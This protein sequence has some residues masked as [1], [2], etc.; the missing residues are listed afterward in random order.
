MSHSHSDTGRW[1]C[2]VADASE[3]SLSRERRGRLSEQLVA[4]CTSKARPAP[5]A[6][7]PR[8]RAARSSDTE[9]AEGQEDGLVEAVALEGLVEAGAHES[10]DNE[11]VGEQCEEK[12]G[13]EEDE[14]HAED[15]EAYAGTRHGNVLSIILGSDRSESE[16]ES[17][18]GSGSEAMRGWGVS[19]CVSK[20]KSQFL[21]HVER[22]LGASL[23]LRPLPSLRT[24]QHFPLLWQGSL[25]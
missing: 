12:L 24:E 2:I 6:P 4:P 8:R 7:A 21:W 14:A 9:D 17:G 16:S 20:G 11:E 15:E 10:S 18:S 5:L 13:E 19:K 3:S 25:V 22:V 23:P 1:G